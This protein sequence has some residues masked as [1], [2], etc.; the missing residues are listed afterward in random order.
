M[1][2]R[3]TY[4]VIDAYI[5]RDERQQKQQIALAWRTAALHRAKRMPAL[6]A[7][8]SEGPAKPLKGKELEK[9]RREFIEVTTSI[10]LESL[11]RKKAKPKDEQPAR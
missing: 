7:L 10:D 2:P 6:R 3:E 9:R 11:N 1:T 8:L 5:W 4:A